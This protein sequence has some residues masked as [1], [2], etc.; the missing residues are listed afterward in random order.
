MET[1]E[2][3]HT[4][5]G[6]VQ[7]QTTDVATRLEASQQQQRTALWREYRQLLDKAR[8][9]TATADEETRLGEVMESLGLTKRHLEKHLEVLANVEK[10]QAQLDGIKAR[11]AEDDPSTA[12]AEI[13]RI[14]E[15]IDDLERQRTSLRERLNRSGG[16]TYSLAIKQKQI[17]HAHRHY[18]GLFDPENADA[19]GKNLPPNAAVWRRPVPQAYETL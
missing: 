8:A 6:E 9:S 5:T 1:N 3:M 13:N 10:W 7:A 19:E 15:Q 4:E 14:N 18:A 16:R 11:M 2:A 12:E 17:D